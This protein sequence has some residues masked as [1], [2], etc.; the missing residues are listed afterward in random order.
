MLTLQPPPGGEQLTA[1]KLDPATGVLMSPTTTPVTLVAGLAVD[2]SGRFLYA[3][4]ADVFAP[5]IDIFSSD[6]KSGSLTQDGAFVLTTI[7]PLCA[8]VNGPGALATDPQ[9]H[10]LY[11]GSNTFGFGLTEVVGG[12]SVA[13]GTGALNFVPGSPFSADDVPFYL[14]VH[15]GGH[16]LFTVNTPNP[17]DF[18]VSGVS[19]FSIDSS[20]GALTPV[21][22]SPFSVSLHADLAGFAIHPSGKYL[23]VSTA[24]SANGILAWSVDTATGA[25]SPLTESPFAP[26]TSPVGIAINPSGKFLYSA[27]PLSGGGIFGFTIDSASGALTPL[28]GSPFDMSARLGDCTI[29]PSG[30]F[31]LAADATNK[32]LVIFSIDAS[33]GALSQIGSPTPLDAVPFV[34]LMTKAPQ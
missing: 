2:P 30:K 15:P 20:T 23:Y 5:A 25:L 27:N 4:N 18:S 33:T 16:F 29:D 28:T 14:Q 12:L 6:S 13:A 21:P 11:Y 22:G 32:T 31:L 10:F 8:P 1:F 9:G 34:I 19:G 26:G 7:C 24:K 3:S 17:P